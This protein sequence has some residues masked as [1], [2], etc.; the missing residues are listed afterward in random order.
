MGAFRTLVTRYQKQ[1]ETSDQHKDE[2]L[3]THYYKAGFEKVFSAVEAWAKGRQ[4]FNVTSVSKGHGEIGVKL[5]KPNSLLVIT[6]I[7]P[8]PFETAVDFMIS[9]EK[10][11]ISGMYPTLRQLISSYYNEMDRLLPFNGKKTKN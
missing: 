2:R 5:A 10:S 9:T 3:Q 6:I 8:R 4:D 1:C 11:S 7:S